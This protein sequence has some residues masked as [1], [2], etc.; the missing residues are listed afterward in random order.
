MASDYWQHA[1]DIAQILSAIGTCGAV[2]AALYIA[3]SPPRQHM[4]GYVGLRLVIQQGM[5]LP[6]PEYLNFCV[7]NTEEVIS[8][9]GPETGSLVVGQK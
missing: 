7:T 8:Y 4:K 1:V 9:S 5:E 2:V 3:Q 6:Y